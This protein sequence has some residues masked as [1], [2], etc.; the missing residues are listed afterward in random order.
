MRMVRSLFLCMV[1]LITGWI[2]VQLPTAQ[3]ANWYWLSSDDKYSKYFDPD[4]V[5]VVNKVKTKQGTEVPTVIE[6]WTKTSYTYGGAEETIKN[7]EIQNLIPNPEMLSYSLAL[8][9]IDPQNRTIQYAREDFYNA[10]GKVIWSKLDGRVK[11]INSE[12]FDE[13][14]YTAMVDEV[15]RHG[16]TAR[17][18]ADDRWIQ[19]WQNTDSNGITTTVTADTTTMRN[20]NSN[21]VLWEWS[22][23]K[24][25]SGRVV[26]ILFMKKAI[27][28]EEGTERLME[29]ERW[30]PEA[31]WKKINDEMDGAYSMINESDPSYKGL[32]RL[33]AWNKGYS[34]WINRYSVE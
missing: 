12:S 23:A 11:E 29:G 34:T 30:T 8:F 21:L 24:N 13:V 9:K 28:L 7:Y 3:A 1:L 25:S 20:K 17:R 2:T 19:L 6:G 16:E 31:G 4:S 14:F 33:R 27:R 10:S 26:E 18:L 5:K 15:F 32:V 22:E